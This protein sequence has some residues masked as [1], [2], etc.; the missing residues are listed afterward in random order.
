MKAGGPVVCGLFLSRSG[1]QSN[2]HLDFHMPMLLPRLLFQL[3]HSAFQF[4]LEIW[5]YMQLEANLHLIIVGEVLRLIHTTMHQLKQSWDM[6]AHIELRGSYNP[7]P[8]L[9]LQTTLVGKIPNTTGLISL[10][11]L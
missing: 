10:A 6:P 3:G 1:S 11:T 8:S 9:A 2:N 4:L 5:I 7:V